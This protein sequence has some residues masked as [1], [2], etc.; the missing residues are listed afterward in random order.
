MARVGITDKQLLK[1]LIQDG[2]KANLA[3][4]SCT[5]LCTFLVAFEKLGLRNKRD[6]FEVYKAIRTKYK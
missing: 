4:F 2:V 5:S 3:D 1:K 6:T